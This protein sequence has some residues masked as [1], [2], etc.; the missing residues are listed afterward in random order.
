MHLLGLRFCHLVRLCHLERRYVACRAR[1]RCKTHHPKQSHFE[2]SLGIRANAQ[3]AVAHQGDLVVELNGLGRE[4]ASIAAKRLID[5]NAVQFLDEIAKCGL[6]VC[7][8]LRKLIA[9]R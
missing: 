9:D 5:R 2:S 8:F 6:E 7:G 3:I 4:R 1:V